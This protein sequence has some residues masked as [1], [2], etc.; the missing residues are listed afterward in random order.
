M[1]IAPTDCRQ[2]EQI[3]VLFEFLF[4]KKAPV[5]TE[6]KAP[7]GRRCPRVNPPSPEWRVVIRSFSGTRLT[8]KLL[9][10]S[11]TGLAFQVD[12]KQ[13]ELSHDDDRLSV[14]FFMPRSKQTLT[15]TGRLVWLYR[16]PRDAH[17]KAGIKF[18]RQNADVQRELV[19]Y[20]EA[21]IEAGAT[22]DL[23]QDKSA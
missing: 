8:P 5:E 17:Y 20:L 23:L 12:R 19:R 16:H 22:V 10:V 4:K 13:G 1:H 21:M 15:V 14:E 3:P 9:N 18:G 7:E 2:E 6:T 11:V